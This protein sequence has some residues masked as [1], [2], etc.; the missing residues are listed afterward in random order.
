[1]G[2]SRSEWTDSIKVW[3]L[4]ALIRA[5]SVTDGPAGSGSCALWTLPIS[6]DR[7]WL[8]LVVDDYQVYA[9]GRFSHPDELGVHFYASLLI[10]IFLSIIFFFNF[11]SVRI[12]SCLR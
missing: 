7:E 5:R 8:D 2:F 12:I 3:D 10:S 1:M 6:I 9:Y 4:R 11:N